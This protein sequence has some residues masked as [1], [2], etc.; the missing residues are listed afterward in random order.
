M[1]IAPAAVTP[2]ALE[3]QPDT[4]DYDHDFFAWALAHAALLRNGR[5][6]QADLE[7]IAEEIEGLARSDRRAA[8][9]YI[10]TILEHM[11]KLRASRPGTTDRVDEEHRPG[12]A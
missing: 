3:E 12:A 11:M 5:P 2:A 8:V 1:T 7:N 4:P 10:G 9:S 6:D